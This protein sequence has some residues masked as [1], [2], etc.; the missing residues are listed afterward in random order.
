[1]Q[2]R[3]VIIGAGQAGAQAVATLRAE[4]FDGSILMIGDELYA[5][6]QRPPL[7]KTY[8]MGTMERDRLFLKPDA[9]YAEAKCELLL[10]VA[11]MSI[12]RAAKTVAL[13]DGHSLGYDKLLIATG[14]RVRRIKVPGAE[15]PGTHYL[16]SI[17]DVDELRPAFEASKNLVIVG[18]GYIGLEVAAVARKY[19]L[20]V[21]VIEALERVMA[22]SASKPVSAFYERVH[23]EAGVTFHLNT[24]VEGFEGKDRLT[25]VR[26]GGKVFPAGNRAGR[27]WRG[28]EL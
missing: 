27:H 10:G 16:R 15:L 12:D 25:S 7:S 24:S 11:A 21:T 13:S 19:D 17:A 20:N 1:M 6:Y 9:F 23:R 3:I 26:A 14:T 2:E 8:L 5:P 18:A 28:S 4:G 22:R